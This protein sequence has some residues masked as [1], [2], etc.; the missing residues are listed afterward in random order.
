VVLADPRVVECVGAL[1]HSSAMS[2]RL[3]TRF[4]GIAAAFAAL[5]PVGASHAAAT[6]VPRY[7][8]FRLPDGAIERMIGAAYQ[9]C[10]DASGGVTSAMRD[11]AAAE[12][13]RLDV[14]LNAAY[15]AALARLP[16][17]AARTRL[18]NLERRWLATRW[19]GCEREA[20]A[21]GGG[22]MAL[23]ILDSCAL[24]EMVRRIAW[25]ELS[26]R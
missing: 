4:I 23:L 2:D 7:E 25:L 13:E 21:E 22:T 19:A 1:G 8:R 9:S 10:M 12:H 14:R 11:C 24:S 17:Q 18:R 3:T 20:R 15:R 26:G 5:L 6:A 16:N